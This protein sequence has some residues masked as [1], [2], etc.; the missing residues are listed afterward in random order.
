MG[1]CSPE[2]YTVDRYDMENPSLKGLPGFSA[3]YVGFVEGVPVQGNVP[4]DRPE[5]N[6]LLSR[7]RAALSQMHPCAAVS[8]IMKEETSI[9]AGGRTWSE[10]IV[11]LEHRSAVVVAT[12]ADATGFSRSL[13]PLLKCL[14]VVKLASELNRRDIAAVPLLW[15]TL[16]RVRDNDVNNGGRLD[17]PGNVSRPAGD[18]RN[19]LIDY[20]NISSEASLKSDIYRN[21]IC[22]LLAWLARDFGLVSVDS[23]SVGL[24]LDRSPGLEGLRRKVSTLCERESKGR[25]VLDVAGDDSDASSQH[26]AGLSGALLLRLSLPATAEVIGPEEFASA[27]I[28][29]NLI[30]AA[31]M[32]KPFLWPRVSATIVDQRSRRT[33][34]KFGLGLPDV[35]KGSAALL[36]GLEIDL[37]ASEVSS[38]LEALA[39]HIRAGIAEISAKASG[40]PRIGRRV[41]ASGSKILYQL[42][43]IAVRSRQSADAQHDIAARQ[44]EDLCSRILPGGA[45]QESRLSSTKFL[46]MHSESVLQVLYRKIDVWDLNHQL[47][48]LD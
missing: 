9:V 13:V 21:Q 24:R 42:R 3:S 45:L 15:V 7:C 43:K 25:A 36:R 5:K 40:D 27:A 29:S 31:G 14:T 35:L 34:A 22:D 1:A 19:K 38:R 17:H 44:L 11:R 39:G 8:E 26:P 20:F 33:M 37:S 48:G 46:S 2:P 16:G 41:Q 6:L 12:S 32:P 28:L 18:S 30:G 4:P 23:S 47:I 10:N